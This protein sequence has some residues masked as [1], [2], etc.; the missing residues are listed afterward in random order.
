MILSFKSMFRRSP[1]AKIRRVHRSEWRTYRIDQTVSWPGV[2]ARTAYCGFLLLPTSGAS[3]SGANSHTRANC[4]TRA[5]RYAD[6]YSYADAHTHTDSDSN[7]YTD[8]G[9][10]RRW[11]P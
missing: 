4:H 9:Q 6:T 8:T 5:N 2:D 7:A 1:Y 11:P 10:R 3:N